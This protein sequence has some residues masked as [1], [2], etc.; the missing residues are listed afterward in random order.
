MY[1][2]KF[3]SVFVKFEELY[4]E[5]LAIRVIRVFDVLYC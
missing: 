5:A 1:L 3:S 2:Y 4:E